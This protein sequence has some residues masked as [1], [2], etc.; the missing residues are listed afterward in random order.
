MKN[1]EKE[2]K[3]SQQVN[4]KKC[5]I[6]KDISDVCKP[7]DN[8]QEVIDKCSEFELEYEDVVKYSFKQGKL[9]ERERILKIIDGEVINDFLNDKE[10]IGVLKED[11][12]D[13]ELLDYFKEFIKQ[14]IENGK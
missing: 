9:A 13:E 5:F 3:K 7:A 2:T 1:K 4:V 10:V 6:A 8:I 12:C 14:Q 11:Y